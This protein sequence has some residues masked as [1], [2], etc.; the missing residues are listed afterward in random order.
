MP[1]ST[2]P[3]KLASL[4]IEHKFLVEESFDPEPLYAALRALAPEREA[5]AEIRERYYLAPGSGYILRH[6]HDA[7]RQ[8]LTL[9]QRRGAGED[10]EVRHELSL[11][12]DPRAGDQGTV[13]RELLELLALRQVG[14]LTK[15]L[16]AFDFADC[17]VVYYR[18]TTDERTVACVEFEALGPA[19]VDA[20]RLVLSRYEAATGFA[21]RPRASTSLFDLLF[22]SRFDAAR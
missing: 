11:A 8:R 12:L 1:N 21:G 22:G 17:E 19:S 7:A 13:V 2:V 15:R 5:T 14:E 10:T 3:G 9:K 16:H 6:S 18:A 20:A 4:E